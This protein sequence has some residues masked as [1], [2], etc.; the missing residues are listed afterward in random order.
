MRLWKTLQIKIKLD[1]FLI[2][3]SHMNVDKP[4]KF[5]NEIMLFSEVKVPAAAMMAPSVF[6]RTKSP[7][8]SPG[9]LPR[10]LQVKSHYPYWV[11]NTNNMLIAVA[12][13]LILHC[14]LMVIYNYIKTNRQF[15]MYKTM[16]CDCKLRP[17][18]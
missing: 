4:S 10:K 17:W 12:S 7:R 11:S 3:N 1:I 18:T 5:K 13:R 8:S 14:T 16:Q 2:D 6:Q 9:T 15:E